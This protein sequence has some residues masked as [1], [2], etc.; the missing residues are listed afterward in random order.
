MPNTSTSLR[1]RLNLRWLILRDQLLTMKWN[2]QCG[3]RIRWTMICYRVLT[4]IARSR[5]NHFLKRMSEFHPILSMDAFGQATLGKKARERYQRWQ[6]ELRDYLHRLGFLERC[7]P[8]MRSKPYTGPL[9]MAI[10]WY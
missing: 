8:G 4:W 10:D 9:M 1:D 7:E 6:Y 5:F 3:L 2:I